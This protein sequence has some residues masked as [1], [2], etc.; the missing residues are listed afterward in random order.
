MNPI[1]RFQSSKPNDVDS[2]VTD[3][4]HKNNKPVS[5][6]P[7]THVKECEQQAAFT[8]QCA[9]HFKI[10]AG[11]NPARTLGFEILIKYLNAHMA[12]FFKTH[13]GFD[14]DW[15]TEFV[16]SIALSIHWGRKCEDLGD[17]IRL[18]QMSYRLFTGK[19]SSIWLQHKLND[20]LKPTT[21]QGFDLDDTLKTLRSC[22]DTAD[23]V[24][25]SPIVKRLHSIYS[26]LLVQG[27]LQRL[28]L[29]LND[30]E[31]SKMEQ[32]ALVSSF[33]SK[34]GFLYCVLETALFIAERVQ[35]WNNTGKWTVFTQSELVYTEW[36]DKSQELL[37][38]APHLSN[39][40]AHNTTYF[41]FLSD[42]NDSIEKGD[43]YCKYMK[44][45]SGISAG[46]M[47][48]RLNALKLLKNTEITRRAAQ[49]E[50]QAPFGVLV[51]GGSSIAKSAFTKMLYTYYG[52]LFG[53]DCDDHFRYVR[54]PMDEYWSNFDSSKWCIQLDDIAFLNPAKTSDVD[55]TLQDLLNVVNNVPYVPP[56]AALEDK[57]KTPVMAKLVVATS[58]SYDLNAHE[59]FHCPLAVR[60]R[61]PYVITLT[62]KPEF[63][64]E[65][66]RFIDPSKIIIK[67][68]KFPDLWVIN[69]QKLVP[70][71]DQGREKARLQTVKIFDD[72]NQ[73]LAHFGRACMTHQ[74]QQQAAMKADD[75]MRTIKVCRVCMKPEPHQCELKP[76]Q[77]QASDFQTFHHRDADEESLLSET[78]DENAPV[79][80]IFNEPLIIDDEED[81]EESEPTPWFWTR[82]INATIEYS[83][84]WSMMWTLIR[85][86]AYFRSVR[87]MLGHFANW[88]RNRLFQ[89][90]LFGIFIARPQDAKARRIAMA[91]GLLGSCFAAYQMYLHLSGTVSDDS[92]TKKM[93]EK[94][95][96]DQQME[97]QGNV[98][99]T[100][101][102][103]LVK[104]KNQNVWYNPT[105]ELK[106]FDL[107]LASG[108]LVGKDP[109]EL[110]R[111]FGANCVLLHVRGNNTQTSVRHVRG[112]FIRGHQCI[113]NAHGFRDDSDTYT[114]TVIQ[115]NNKLALNSNLTLEMKRSDVSF[116]ETSDLCMFE[117]PSLPPF[118]DI[119]KFWAE[120]PLVW[121]SGL[122]LRREETG[123]VNLNPIYGL[124]FH[125]GFPVEKMPQPR[126]DVVMGQS[127]D[128][129]EL[130]Q[131]G[132][133]L[134][135]TTPRGPAL[136]GLH[137]LGSQHTVGFL[138]VTLS[139]IE[140]LAQSDIISKRPI[141]Q[142]GGGPNL[143]C[144]SRTTVVTDLHHRSV[145]RYVEEGHADVFGSFEGFRRRPKS[146]VCETPL[147][148]EFL[149]L[150]N[151]E[152]DYGKPSMSGYEPWRN[153]VVDMIKPVVNYDRGVLRHCVKEFTRD[154]LTGLPTGWEAELVTLSD[155]AAVN[156][157]PGVKYID[158]MNMSTSMGHPWGKSKDQFMFS[159]IDERYP[160]GVNFENEIWDR[161]HAIEAKYLEGLRAFPVFTGHLKDEAT[162]LKKC[163]IHKTRL[164]TGAPGD[165]SIVVR[166][167][168]LPLV[169]LVQKNKLVFEAGPGTVTQSAE[170]GVI[171]DYLT[172]H[173]V[174]QMVAGDY[175][176]YDK[177]MIADLVLAA[178]EILYN[179][180]RAAGYTEE[181]GRIILCIGEDTAFPL[182]DCNGDLMM[183]FGT[184]P[185]GHPL[186]VI[187]NSLVNSLYM[188]YCYTK[189][190]P[191]QTCQTFKSQVALFTYG[192]DNVMGV[193][194]KAPWFNHTAIANVLKTIGVIY[195]MADKEAVSV[196]YININQVSFLKRIWRWEPE[197]N[198]WVCPLEEKSIIKSL[199]MWCP[200]KSIDKYKQMVSVMSSA[201]SEYFFYGRKKFE[202][203]HAIFT[204]ICSQSPYKSYVKESTLPNFDLLAERFLSSSGDLMEQ[205]PSLG[206]V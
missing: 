68:G 8:R 76:P 158:R 138:V 171:Y 12:A 133:L 33:S 112:V 62:P 18:T 105:V 52:A 113:T 72:V 167:H 36:L 163:R 49:Q 100:T 152:N 164:F 31:Y 121:S 130:G 192:D 122:E 77:I 186:T 173:G 57:G 117:V 126:Y 69:V 63:I 166:K 74:S 205:T 27:F 199:T 191:E 156:G 169:R 44:S 83:I 66:G 143:S 99:G 56:Q 123:E 61:L 172:Q 29:S 20:F 125:K 79:I 157:L 159:D 22:F 165:W 190:N 183:F 154:I 142:G 146:T 136:A 148:N 4:I 10:Q 34:R 145:L 180:C 86:A 97:L 135:A 2:V 24:Q 196:P 118:R 59:Y 197:V 202:E 15:F 40:S 182:T 43:A 185:S 80:D 6:R 109:P 30:E 131:C 3:C 140:K 137:F 139:D 147:A 75:G 88:T 92:E 11:D 120:K 28:G 187:I 141:V 55:S 107:P 50:R 53:L 168:L 149:T 98:F 106:Q 94:E 45:N 73:F 82:F 198:N 179:I 54:N 37:N 19:C 194:T 161:V 1:N 144:A 51:H 176:K 170:W 124:E 38:L 114:V 58:N 39:L 188:R 9:K 184:N 78:V 175:G 64:H 84:R 111:L 132:S 35:Q 115:S 116:S 162:P 26:Y 204:E 91:I 87:W 101:E 60:R 65:N 103:Q 200:S 177:R 47:A 90:K 96:E 201:N 160:E 93:S 41:S 42:L 25:E 48:G 70:I 151:V 5:P 178:F 193:S 102:T 181:E 95:E 67:K 46:T 104:E 127:S 155:K 85:W 189:L 203:M 195:T 174:G 7:Y 81:D 110:R 150:Y 17:Y 134:I 128:L 153:N 13:P 206:A 119:T 32:R 71:M 108:S 14:A 23:A 21:V 16:E 129:T 89:V